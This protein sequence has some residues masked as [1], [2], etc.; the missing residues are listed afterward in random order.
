V[1]CISCSTACSWQAVTVG[2]KGRPAISD[3]AC[4]GC[5]MCVA[6]CPTQAISIS[7]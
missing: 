2:A 3:E 5:G 7:D 1:I 4:T 6:V